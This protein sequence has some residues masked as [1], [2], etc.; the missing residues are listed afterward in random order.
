MS[1]QLL[2]LRPYKTAVIHALQPHNP[3][4]RVHFYSWLL[5]SAVKDDIDSQLISFSDEA[6]F[7]L[8]GY[9]NTQNNR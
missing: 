7:H 8:Q 3:A 4:I 9:I 5:Q 2:K 1:T 6:W